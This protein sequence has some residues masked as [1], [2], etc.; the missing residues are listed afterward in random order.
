[1]PDQSFLPHIPPL[2]ISGLT[3][4][5][6][7]QVIAAF[8]DTS[9]QSRHLRNRFKQLGEAHS[10][11]GCRFA[12]VDTHDL[13]EKCGSQ[14]SKECC[15]P[16]IL[17][18]HGLLEDHL[19]LVAFLRHGQLVDQVVLRQRVGTEQDGQPKYASNPASTLVD[20]D[21]FNLLVVSCVG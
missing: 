20:R 1:M 13:L 21:S 9:D 18:Q 7:A 5:R 8:I 2:A 16:A 14:A 4:P 19:P 17:Q 12:V 10:V 15:A 11:R 3:T 6:T